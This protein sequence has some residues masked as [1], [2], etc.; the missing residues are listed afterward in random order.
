MC[1]Q[2]DLMPP[3]AT[4]Q[5]GKL[6]HCEQLRRPPSLPPTSRASSCNAI[7][8]EKTVVYRQRHRRLRRRLL[9]RSRPSVRPIEENHVMSVGGDSALLNAWAE[10]WRDAGWNPVVLTLEDA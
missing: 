1:Q 8:A 6:D 4:F 9:Q 5:S 10:A 7:K 3:P 2:P